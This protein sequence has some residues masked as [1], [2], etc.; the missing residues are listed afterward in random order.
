MG[1]H[2]AAGQLVLERV[3]LGDSFEA[4]QEVGHRRSRGLP[5]A[6]LE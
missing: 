2:P 4:F 3:P 5:P 1:S 6:F